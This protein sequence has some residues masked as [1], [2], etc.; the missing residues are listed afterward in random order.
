MFKKQYQQKYLIHNG[1]LQNIGSEHK[2]SLN[3][4]VKTPENIERFYF[5]FFNA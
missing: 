2:K 5:T 4:K 1:D 3:K